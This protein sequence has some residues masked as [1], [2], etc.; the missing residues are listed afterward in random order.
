ME[1]RGALEKMYKVR[2]C[3]GEVFLYAIITG[4]V[5]YNPALDLASE[6]TPPKK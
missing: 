6:L 4:Q 3:C 2:W 5:E 1:K